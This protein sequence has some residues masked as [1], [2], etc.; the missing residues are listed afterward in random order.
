VKQKYQVICID[1]DEQFINSLSSSLPGKMSPI[2]DE[3]DCCFEFVTSIEELGEVMAGAADDTQ[4]A[5]LVSDQMMTGMTGIDLIE[6]IKA[7]HPDIMCV[8]LTGN[9]A[10]DSVKYAVNRR[11]LDQYVSKPIDDIDMFVSMLANLLKRYHVNRE[12]HKRT[13]QLA[14]IVIQ[15]RASNQKISTMLATTEQIALLAKDLKNLEFDK[16]AAMAVQ[17][18]VKIFKAQRGVLCLAPGGCSQE[19][20]SRHDCPCAQSDLISRGE[21][22]QAGSDDIVICPDAKGLSCGALGDNPPQIMIPLA[23]GNLSGGDG[24]DKRRGYLC[25]CG[26]N[27]EVLASPDLLAYNASLVR[28]ILA[29]S[30]ASARLFQQVKNDSE[31]DCLTGIKTRRFLND[32]LDAEYERS[33][34][35][36][37]PFCIMI[38]D[39][40]HFK[41]VN[42]N[43]GHQAGD[44]ILCELADVLSREIRTPDVLARYGGDEFAVLSPQT[45]LVGAM[46]L[47]ERMRKMVES[48]LAASGRTITIS[49]GV[50]EWSGLR[51]ETVADVLRRADAALYQAKQAG[52]NRVRTIKAAPSET[53]CAS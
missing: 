23:V 50:A 26:V 24:N 43:F 31:I 37:H 17:G 42:D 27:P 6:K 13:E 22:L 1:D 14:R 11:L 29:A 36:E 10:A 49:C 8:L 40:D 41:Q 19:T 21:A 16:I 45:N 32:V 7:Q 20:T 5:M 52:R 35:Y 3:F 39:V 15:L 4:L 28:D 33:L 2:C 12:E 34:R 25:M 48:S 46:G 44:K 18:A 51:N 38:I 47:A 30:L 53:P 9:V